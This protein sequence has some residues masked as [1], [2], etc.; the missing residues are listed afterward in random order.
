MCCSPGDGVRYLTHVCIKSVL[1][2]A[3]AARG[4]LQVGK[5]YNFPDKRMRAVRP[6]TM[7]STDRRV[8]HYWA[9]NVAPLSVF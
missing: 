8:V 4:L 1:N 2:G 3:S 7:H 9:N 6:K 5:Q